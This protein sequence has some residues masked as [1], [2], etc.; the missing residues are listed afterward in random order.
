MLSDVPI[1]Q[2]RY[3]TVANLCQNNQVHERLIEEV[4]AFHPIL[5][6]RVPAV[7]GIANAFDW[8]DTRMSIRKKYGS[9]VSHVEAFY[10]AVLPLVEKV[11]NARNA[12][13]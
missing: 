11:Q 3:V 1:K 10:R 7:A 2:R 13:E 4:A 5:D 12:A 6:C 9:A 8:Q